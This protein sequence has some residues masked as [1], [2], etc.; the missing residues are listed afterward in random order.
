[1]LLAC[2][3]S[4]HPPPDFDANVLVGDAMPIDLGPRPDA[5]ADAAEAG[6]DAGGSEDADAEPPDSGIDCMA[7]PVLTLS[8]TLAAAR[9]STLAGML[10]EVTGT[11]TIG[12]ETCTAT[13][14]SATMPCCNTCTAPIAIDG[15]LPLE[16]SAECDP[17]RVGCAGN[18]C[19]LSCSPPVAGVPQRF[20]G[21]LH[22]G[23]ALELYSV[24]EF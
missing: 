23:P 20:V 16:P 5:R 6:T 14:C 22:Q 18:E 4:T 19:T 12:I 15:L 24:H 3:S 1:L 13:V 7:T 17:H 21:V 10:V 8:A 11:A 2:S 9:A